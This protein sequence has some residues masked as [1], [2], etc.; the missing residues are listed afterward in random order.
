LNPTQRIFV[1]G[2][3]GRTGTHLISALLSRG[4]LVRAVSSR[5]PANSA[6]RTNG[7]DWHR[8]DWQKDIEFSG[9]L[10]GCAAVLHLGA[11]ITDISAMRRVNVEATAALA[12]EAEHAGIRFFCYTSSVAVYGSPRRRVVTED[13]PTV[14]ADQDVSQ[15]YLA[16]DAARAYSRSKLLGERAIE[17]VA[18]T[19]E[20]V[21]LRPTLIA[22]DMDIKELLD[23][24]PARRLLIA[25]RHTH[26]LH[27][28]DFVHA[29][30][31]FM[32]RAL[33][34]LEPEPGVQVFN[35]SNDDV[36][37]NTIAYFL[38]KA[39]LVTGDKRY[40]CPPHAPALIDL[41]ATMLKYRSLQLR[42]PFGMLRYSPER[43]Y[44]TGYRHALGILSAQDRLLD[45][46]STL[47]DRSV[48]GP[49][50]TGDRIH[51]S[52]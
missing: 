30:L 15:E 19:C 16:S 36:T 3:T 14:T 17:A 43:L 8:M 45:S 13:T 28:T 34:R 26:Q 6:E 50:L 21:I 52:S 31:W 9:L 37:F 4:Y 29:I 44:A 24:S 38:R 7:L 11:Q 20:Y 10:E 32:E 41:I 35:L 18:R 12:A 2:G 48:A 25:S 5:P 27:V 46:L 23:L 47:P 51:K 1:T 42:Y 33:T 22:S 39:R 49:P 40:A